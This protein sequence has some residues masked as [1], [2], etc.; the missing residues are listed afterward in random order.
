MFYIY[1]LIIVVF[2]NNINIA[3]VDKIIKKIIFD[4]KK[5]KKFYNLIFKHII[6]KNCLK[7]ANIVYYN[8]NDNCIKF[9][10]KLLSEIIDLNNCL[11]YLFYVQYIINCIENTL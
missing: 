3:N 4:F 1:I 9:F 10:S 11:N 8:K 6:Y 5:N 2:K 7:N